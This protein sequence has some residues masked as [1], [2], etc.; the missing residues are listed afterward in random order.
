MRT[1]IAVGLIILGSSNIWAADSDLFPLQGLRLEMTSSDLLKAYPHAKTAFVTKD[2]AG[3]L[4]EGLVL[5]EIANSA[6]WDSALIRVQ[7]GKVQSWSY[8][9]T[10]DFDRASRSVGAIHNALVETID[11]TSEKKVTFHL[12]TQGKVRSPVFVWKF[13]DVFAA[14]T[15]SPVK[16]HKS[17]EAFICQLTIFPDIKG[18][19]SL[20]DVAT[21][22]KDKDSELFLEVTSGNAKADK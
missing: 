13:G 19:Q 17:G 9:S 6:Y 5:C 15:H 8:V 7:E 22:A 18:L 2:G 4:T 16:E 10:K 12:L 21:D 14:F 3:Q 11:G 20:F 1:V